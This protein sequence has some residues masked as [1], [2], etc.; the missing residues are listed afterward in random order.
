MKLKTRATVPTA[1]RREAEVPKLIERK[2]APAKP[3]IVLTDAEISVRAYSYWEA[4]NSGDGSA[5]DDWYHAIADLLR[6]RSR[7][8]A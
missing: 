3:A 8:T 2:T 1:S 7:K 5:E 6:E 4:R